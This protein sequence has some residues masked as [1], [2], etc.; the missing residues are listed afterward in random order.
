MPSSD[1]RCSLRFVLRGGAN[2]LTDTPGDGKV[3]PRPFELHFYPSLAAAGPMPDGL[4][5]A[6]PAPVP[7]D[8]FNPVTL[9]R[10]VVTTGMR[11]IEQDKIGQ[12]RW[13]LGPESAIAFQL[14]QARELS[15]QLDFINVIQDQQ[16][17]IIANGKEL[18]RFNNLPQQAWLREKTSSM[19]RF[20]GQ[21]GENR[22][23]IRYE[24]WNGNG[25]A[26]SQQD[27]S[28]YAVAFT[29]LIIQGL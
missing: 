28:P 6:F 9:D 23:V 5:T 26:V 1:Q 15:L 22:I 10:S 16:M 24:K 7:G 17:V 3:T 11:S 14:D 4:P 12:W 19:V 21:P 20:Q 29:R 25:A 8:L 13:G 2:L 27:Q 18:T